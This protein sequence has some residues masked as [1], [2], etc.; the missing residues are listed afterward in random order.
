VIS[1]GRQFFAPLLVCFFDFLDVWSHAINF[2][3]LCRRGAFRLA[4]AQT[5][6]GIRF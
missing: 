4:G 5:A 3:P 1:V 2:M 6:A